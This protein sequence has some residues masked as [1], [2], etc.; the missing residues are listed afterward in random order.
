MGKKSNFTQA[1]RELTGFD[2]PSTDNEVSDS[3]SVMD[4]SADFSKENISSANFDSDPKPSFDSF[5][6]VNNKT[7]ITKSMIVKGDIKSSDHINIEGQVF[8]NITT[9]ENLKASNLII[10]NLKANNILLSDARIKGNLSLSSNLNIEANSI[11]VGDI[12]AE[13]TK[14]AGKVKG[15]LN[16]NN[17]TVLVENALVV[18]D[19]TA[20]DISTESG[21]RIQGLIKTRNNGFN[22]DEDSEFDL[23]GDF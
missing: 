11:I 22:Y 10:G 3:S 2:D 7:V 5:D 1:L 12:S 21:A 17:S 15:N 4:F 6:E 19:I 23:G 16:I 8:G 14:I 20:N 13:N 18:G 9:S